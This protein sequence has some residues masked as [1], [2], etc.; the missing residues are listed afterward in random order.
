MTQVV[1]GA[2]EMVAGM[3]PDLKPECYVFCAA[4]DLDWAALKPLAM[5]REAEGVSLI[6]ETG[7]AEIAGL[8]VRNP[9]ALITLNV[10]SA[11]DGVGLTAAVAGALAEAG[12]ACNMVAALNHDH[13][14]VPA[15]RATQAL[16]ILRAL[17]AAA[18]AP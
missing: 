14:F 7:A 12:I 9:M 6:L 1:R 4:G 13:V 8:P 2:R 5:F 18:N 10:Y 3:M 11:L 17:Q 16:S 15:D